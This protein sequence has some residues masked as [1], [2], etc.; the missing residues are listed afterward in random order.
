LVHWYLVPIVSVPLPFK[1]Q[2]WTFFFL[3]NLVFRVLF[4]ALIP[5][6][7]SKILDSQLLQLILRC[8]C[9]TRT[10]T[11]G[12]YAWCM[13]WECHV[14]NL[15]SYDYKKC[16]MFWMMKLHMPTLQRK[17]VLVG[18]RLH[19]FF[20]PKLMN[21]FLF[22]SAVAKGRGDHTRHNY[23][24]VHL[25]KEKVVG[26]SSGEEFGHHCSCSYKDDDRCRALHIS[27]GCWLLVYH[28][29][30]TTWWCGSIG[31]SM[32]FMHVHARSNTSCIPHLAL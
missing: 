31:S 23:W 8:Y 15:Q 4:D 12:S 18:F 7:R 16:L 20:L 21:L 9:L 32:R 29:V 28:W 10:Y 27:T 3:V 6:I 19:L 14:T 26:A 30:P 17:G 22:A 5:Q 1:K 24:G 2:L 13:P 11:W 25:K